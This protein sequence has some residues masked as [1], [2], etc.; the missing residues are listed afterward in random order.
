AADAF[1]P[2]D[3]WL[4]QAEPAKAADDPTPTPDNA[5]APEPVVKKVDHAEVFRSQHT[6][7]AVMTKQR[8]GM[9]I[10]NGKLYAPGQSVDGFKLVKVGETEATFTGKDTTVTLRLVAAQAGVAGTATATAR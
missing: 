3:N 8:G 9:A 5:P 4:A 7:N 1:R 10:V 2:C 6:L